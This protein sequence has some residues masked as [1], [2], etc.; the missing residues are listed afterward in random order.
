MA[1]KTKPK[2]TDLPV[3]KGDRFWGMGCEVT[4]LRASATWADVQVKQPKGAEWKKR[5]PLP[6][7]EDWE[8]LEPDLKLHEF[9]PM[10]TIHPGVFWRELVTESEMSQAEI[11]RQMGISQKHLSQILTCTVSPGV[12][13][14]VS[15]AN[16]VGAP[17]TTLWNMACNHKLALALGKKDVTKDYL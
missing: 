2:L 1:T 9:D 14:T 5:Q 10:W 11:A 13:A 6:F 4:V 17:V 8:R 15:F 7:P 3:K 16:V 12:E